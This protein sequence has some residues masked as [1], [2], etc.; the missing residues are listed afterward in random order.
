VDVPP[1][2]TSA[3]TRR[4]GVKRQSSALR[5]STSGVGDATCIPASTSKTR[6]PVT[7]E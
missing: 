1:P 3:I 4:C 7:L 5:R 2:L 6:S